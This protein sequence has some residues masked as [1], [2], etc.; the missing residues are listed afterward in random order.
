MTTKLGIIRELGLYGTLRAAVR[1]FIYRASS[2]GYYEAK[3][4]DIRKP[5]LHGYTA[6]VVPLRTLTPT[7]LQNPNVHDE[8][9]A[10]IP[11]TAITNCV[12]VFHDNKVVASNW[13]IGRTARVPELD[14]II[15]LPAGTYYSSRAYVAPEHRGQRLSAY[16]KA[17]FLD[18]QPGAETLCSFIYDWNTPSIKAVSSSGFKRKGSFRTRWLFGQPWR[19]I[20]QDA[21]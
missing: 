11:S 21:D 5:E 15:R 18:S 7:R 4:G 1:K 12:L 16:M 17:S 13:F 9:F 14:I 6:R 20:R 10:E 8:H 3:R 19:T 2:M